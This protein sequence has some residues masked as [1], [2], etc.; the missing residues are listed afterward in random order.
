MYSPFHFFIIFHKNLYKEN[1][2]SFQPSDLEQ[3][4]RWVS[5][6]ESI[7]KEIPNWLP[8][9]LLITESALQNYTPLYQMN[10]FY[11]NSFLLHLSKNRHL[12]TT[13]YIGFGQ[14]DMKLSIDSFKDVQKLIEQE[15]S[16]KQTLFTAFPYPFIQLYGI[17]SESI[18][19]E[20]LTLYNIKYSTS[21]SY[22]TL[23]KLPLALM[24]TFIIPSN[25]F[26][27]SMDFFEA[28]IPFIIKHLEWNT[29]HMA[30]TLERL[31][32][33]IFCIKVLEQKIQKIVQL[34]N[35]SHTISQRDDDALRNL[36]KEFILNYII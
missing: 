11:Q 10:H 17:L 3:F 34:H 27:E 30:G 25:I 33:F 4:L 9:N 19:R 29:R 18:W 2:D 20:I 21:H 1:T 13:P 12:V 16:L 5:V 32:A 7:P 6:N 22:D 14:Y 36:R 23:Q 15:G 24:H 8:P 31:I 28:T 35:I 26:F